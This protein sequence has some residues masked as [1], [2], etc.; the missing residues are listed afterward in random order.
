MSIEKL[1]TNPEEFKV[2]KEGFSRRNKFALQKRLDGAV[3]CGI[4]ITG[5]EL[6]S[7][8]LIAGVFYYDHANMTSVQIT[9]TTSSHPPLSQDIA[10]W[11][12]KFYQPY[13]QPSSLGGLHGIN[14][15]ELDPINLTATFI[16]FIP[17][18]D[19]LGINIPTGVGMDMKDANTIIVGAVSSLNQP[20]NIA[21]VD[22]SGNTGI[23][24]NLFSTTHTVAGDII[25]MQDTGHVLVTHTIP[26]SLQGGF[27]RLY[28]YNGVV[29]EDTPYSGGLGMYR[30]PNGDIFASQG[31]NIIKVNFNPLS[32]G[33]NLGGSGIGVSGAAYNS[34]PNSICAQKDTYCYN[35]GD[36]GPGGGTIFSVPLGHPQNNGVNQSNFYY[37]VAKN[38]INVGGAIPS[39]IYN[40][41]CGDL[42]QVITVDASWFGQNF[43][44]TSNTQDITFDFGPGT[45]NPSFNPQNLNIGATVQALDAQG[46]NMFPPNTTVTV[47]NKT[48]FPSAPNIVLVE[49][50]T[51]L[52]V[53]PNGVQLLSTQIAT[54]KFGITIA[55]AGLSAAGNEFGA[56]DKTIQT[57]INFG[58]G[59]DNTD[60][61][62]S[63]PITPG[64]H[65]T[66]SSRQIAATECLNHSSTGTYL[67]QPFT[68]GDW[69]LP[70]L[71]EFEEIQNQMT[72]GN[73]PGVGFKSFNAQT[74]EHVY[75]T[76]SA[77]RN[78]QFPGFTMPGPDRWAWVYKNM[79]SGLAPNIAFRCHPLS[80]RPIRR[81]ECEPIEPSVDEGIDYDY[82]L[83]TMGAGTT[84]AV[85]YIAQN[86]AQ[87]L[88]A[89]AEVEAYMFNALNQSTI[90]SGTVI[91]PTNELVLMIDSNSITS[92]VAFA[93]T[94]QLLNFYALDNVGA[95]AYNLFGPVV[96]V[97]DIATHP[98]LGPF[99][100][101]YQAQ[102]GA[103]VDTFL[104]FDQSNMSAFNGPNGPWLGQNYPQFS[105]VDNIEW[106]TLPNIPN[107]N[108]SPSPFF[109]SGVP[110][111]MGG[112]EIGH[113]TL[114][115][116]AASLDVRGNDIRGMLHSA[117][118]SGGNSLLH[119]AVFNVKIYD[120][121]EKLVCDYDYRIMNANKYNPYGTNNPEPHQYP[122]CAFTACYWT[123]GGRLV[124]VNYVDNSLPNAINNIVDLRPYFGRNSNFG[125]KGNGYL[126]LTL[127]NPNN[128][129]PWNSNMTRGNTLN[130][131]NWLGLGNHRSEDPNNLPAAY[132]TQLNRFGWGVVCRPCGTSLPNGCNNIFL[133]E[134]L[135]EVP[136][137]PSTV[138]C[139]YY[140]GSYTMHYPG[141]WNNLS[142]GSTWG[143]GWIDAANAGCPEKS[144]SSTTTSANAKKAQNYPEEYKVCYD[145][146]ESDF[147]LSEQEKEDI[148]EQEDIIVI[149]NPIQET[150]NRRQK[151]INSK[152]PK[153]TGPF[154][155]LG[156]YPLYDTIE[157]A[158]YNSPIPIESR[159]GEDTHGYHI[160][161]FEGVEYYMP[162]GLGGPGS[163]LQFHGDYDGQIIPE[164]I[165]EE[166]QIEEEVV[167]PIQELPSVVT[168]TPIEPEQEEEPPAPTPTPTY[169][170]PPPSTPS[171]GSG[172]GGGGY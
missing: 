170:P 21:E 10:R 167:E 93:T 89:E 101:I 137:G 60:T 47:T 79:P 32:T 12:N 64:I 139:N 6:N 90:Q 92:N 112:M 150:K 97:I 161:E 111:G 8:L 55:A 86:A 41:S 151:L 116:Q 118:V 39:I 140:S 158:V 145:S 69:F 14:E 163:G 88:Q 72:L 44:G 94:S 62:H 15:W 58:T 100:P 19:S 104:V 123:F 67:G 164:I 132:N 65:P 68:A 131:Q 42:K 33:Q 130:L 152:K 95:I 57:S 148:I 144:P 51:P 172:G 80:V 105:F 81:F 146:Q 128:N 82:R 2:N 156:Y 160:H 127:K 17:V 147:I 120:Q 84:G 71:G 49:F 29:L 31:Q 34:N 96:N 157:A 136:F 125:R 45:A 28:N 56:H 20:Y 23:L 103:N 43:P 121:F 38:D 78:N 143:Q 162:N 3:D 53:L 4:L 7:G 149:N 87:F 165:I 40:Q 77:F 122:Q 26:G 129:T 107:P 18:Y 113:K 46:N 16:R 61:I 142:Q 54:I 30:I 83:S 13:S 50:D 119:Q 36:T 114:Y 154:A 138:N 37:E 1:E 66:L 155:I 24:T 171:G 70:S 141:H 110:T 91:F 48:F 117:A 166:Q 11:D 5:T 102:T 85:G 133:K 126:S 106:H 22:I 73:I 52:N 115:I 25:Y 76:S 135:A 9:S 99:L 75:W 168:I 169:T 109:A 74:N 35:I 153:E 98:Q 27:I 134:W 159:T 108:W 59:Q 124:N 63:Y